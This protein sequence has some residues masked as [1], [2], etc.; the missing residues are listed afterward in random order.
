MYFTANGTRLVS[1]NTGNHFMKCQRVFLGKYPDIFSGLNGI[2]VFISCTTPFHHIYFLF[3]S[4]IIF[5]LCN[6]CYLWFLMISYDFQ[7]C[8]P[9]TSSNMR[10]FFD[11]QYV[12][13]VVRYASIHGVCLNQ[14]T[15]RDKRQANIITRYSAWWCAIG[16]N[17]PRG[18]QLVYLLPSTAIYQLVSH[19]CHC[20][21]LSPKIIFVLLG[22]Y[23]PSPTHR[24]CRGP[25]T[26]QGVLIC[27]NLSNLIL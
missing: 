20:S 4:F 6:H 13:S 21:S 18:K 16:L 12:H 8:Y 1:W 27:N 2:G 14:A 17:W 19:H 25:I 24:T 3:I 5:V 15:P 9:L 10:V 23:I 26:F 11:C 22:F 7:C